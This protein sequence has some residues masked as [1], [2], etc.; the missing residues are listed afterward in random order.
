MILESFV[1]KKQNYWS[2]LNNL[3]D[4][5]QSGN[6]KG[7]SAEEIARLGFLYRRVSSD[8]AIAK[9]DFPKD[10]VVTYLNNLATRAYTSVYQSSPIEKNRVFDFFLFGFSQMFR[11]NIIFIAI[12]FLFF[13]S[14]FIITYLVVL[15]NP[16]L[17][18][19][20]VPDELV[21]TIKQQKKWTNIAEQQR[22]IA[23]S[24]IMTNNIR[25]A[26][27]AF[28]SGIAFTLGTV[29]VLL[30]NGALIG[31]IGGLC[32][33]HGLSLILWSF[34]SSHGYIELTVI[35]IAG[36]AGMKMGY[37]L[38]NP[39]LLTR[40][41]ALTDAAKQAV[42]LIGGC[43]PLLIIAGL[44]EGFISP[45]SLPVWFKL[46]FGALSGILLYA[47]L[48]LAGSHREPQR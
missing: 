10:R 46:I 15:D 26:F 17:A 47:Y 16:E 9:R 1:N 18:E 36:G 25:V 11:E 35:F 48:F 22:N 21:E 37:S 7:L 42:K 45:S 8:L 6:I 14:M 12:S 40:K 32:H 23:S 3:L 34:V 19:S 44:I 13:S 31:A 38:I 41:R 39:G 28:A 33:V 5:L 29:Y 27:F 4:K 24:L 43:V 20:L 2:E 30:F